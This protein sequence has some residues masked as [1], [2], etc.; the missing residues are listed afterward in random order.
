MANLIRFPK[1]ISIFAPLRCWLE[2]LEINNPQFAAWLCKIIPVQCPFERQIKL[3]GDAIIYIP[4]MCKLNPF[5]EE[6]MLLRF[7]ALCYLVDE[8]GWEIW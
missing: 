1:A 7:R 5:Y 3:W 4:P 6:L 8:C 2:N